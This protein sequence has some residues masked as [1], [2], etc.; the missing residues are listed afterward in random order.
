MYFGPVL[1]FEWHSRYLNMTYF[2]F[3]LTGS[4]KTG[5]YS[6]YKLNRISPNN[7]SILSPCYQNMPIVFQLQS[8]NLMDEYSYLSEDSGIKN[9]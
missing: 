6:D 8:S 9:T 5:N 3:Q 7:I 2:I 4:G 1:K